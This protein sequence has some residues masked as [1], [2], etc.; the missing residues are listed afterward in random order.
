MSVRGMTMK[1]EGTQQWAHPKPISKGRQVDWENIS[2]TKV[3]GRPRN[4]SYQGPKRGLKRTT[5]WCCRRG[6]GAKLPKR[7]RQKSWP[8]RIGYREIKKSENWSFSACARGLVAFAGKNALRPS[9]ARRPAHQSWQSVCTA[10]NRGYADK[11]K[12]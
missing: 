1:K 8:Y 12:I 2:H 4:S 10:S 7:I 6:S 9:T 3:V 5:L 11:F